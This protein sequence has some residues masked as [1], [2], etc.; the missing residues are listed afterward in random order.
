MNLVSKQAQ[1]KTDSQLQLTA[2]PILHLL[3]IASEQMVQSFGANNNYTM[4]LVIESNMN[5]SEIK[6]NWNFIWKM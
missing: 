3:R 1:N 5:D 4:Q 6:S 2:K